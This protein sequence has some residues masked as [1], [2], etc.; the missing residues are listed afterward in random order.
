MHI[1]ELRPRKDKRGAYPISDALVF[2][3]RSGLS[4]WSSN[5]EHFI[6]TLSLI[7]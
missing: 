6:L 7:E 3:C 4:G 1:Y 2:R 5:Y